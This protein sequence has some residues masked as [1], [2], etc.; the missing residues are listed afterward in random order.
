V[1]SRSEERV[2]VLASPEADAEFY[3]ALTQSGATWEA[4]PDLEHLCAALEAGAGALLLAVSVLA[5]PG[6]ERLLLLLENQPPWSDLPVLLLA[7]EASPEQRSAAERLGN[8]HWLEAPSR[9]GRLTAA[10]RSALRSRRRQYQVR[11]Q[12]Q[13]QATIE[14]GLRENEGRLRF[15]LE[16]GLLGIWQHDMSAD[17]LYCSPLCKT[18]FGRDAEAPLS[19]D[20]VLSTVHPED[21]ERAQQAIIDA[22]RSRASYILEYRVVWPDGSLH[23][24]MVRGHATYTAS[25]QPECTFGVT[26]DITQR[27]LAEA[28][29]AE[30][31]ERLRLLSESAGHLLTTTDPVRMVR[32][33]F[34]RVREYLQL[35]LCLHYLVDPTGQ[36][37]RLASCTGLPAE[38]SE[39][40]S[41]LQFEE[42]LGDLM[43]ELQEP[44]I[45][46]D[47]QRSP[48]ARTELLRSLG[49]RA[50]TC[51]PLRVGDQLLGSLCFA[52]RNRDA[53]SAEDL[54]FLRTITHYVAVAQERVRVEAGLRDAARRKDEFLAMLAHELR[55]PLSPVAGAVEIMRA[56][57]SY[58]QGV[59]ARQVVERQLRRMSRLID[60]LLD[61]SRITTGKIRLQPE[62]L[63][64]I[65]VIAG[66]LESV[67]ELIAAAGHLLE[68]RLPSHPVEVY[69]DPVR[70]EQVILNLVHN[71]AKYTD[72]GGTLTVSLEADA[73]HARLR[74]RDTG[75][76]IAPE[77]LN[78]VF[79]LFT[80]GERD[81]DRS[82]GGLGLGLTLVRNLT[83]LH[84]GTVEASS[85]GPG[86][87]SEFVVTLPL[88]QPSMSPAAGVSLPAGLPS[89][90]KPAATPLPAP[91]RRVLVVDDNRDSAETLAELAELWGFEVDTAFDGLQGLQRAEEWEPSLVFLDIG[92]PGLNGY[93]VAR[94]LRQDVRFMNVTLVALTGYGQPE[95]IE[96]SRA[97]GF[98]HHLV[99]PI[100][101]TQLEKLLPRHSPAAAPPSS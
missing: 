70:L 3:R 35:D 21:R 94:R 28:R 19:H 45:L 85:E 26:L 38:L 46:T 92:M 81:L 91:S 66:A 30:Q 12:F 54:E 64:L 72:P 88:R 56:R 27:K 95:D 82:Q 53:F 61:V 76:G 2:L 99:K 31:A 69:A 89:N 8:V 4:C 11:D 50:G 93:E 15:S 90:A 101:I 17:R 65:Q 37:L 34:E 62:P 24:L 32:E 29:Q 9:P 77:L 44:L 13:Q 87:G 47:L 80:Q 100:D 10:L 16:A 98:D 20:E 68:I 74:V 39:Q 60:D 97:A 23:W 1:S 96:R 48:D 18:H 22:I 40:V 43:A 51:N 78:H 52:V 55:N 49:M 59:R 83:Q 79:D 75:I 14:Q 84:G 42:G 7:P 33:L 36:Q 41:T 86:Q 63:D 71:A 57:P 58:E 67:S 73:S 25:G 6:V 5:A